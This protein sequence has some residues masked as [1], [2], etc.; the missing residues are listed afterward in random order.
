[1]LHAGD[2]QHRSELDQVWSWWHKGGRGVCSL[3]GIGG[4]GKTAIAEKFLD[5][6]LD[7]PD[8]TRDH[9]NPP[10]ALV[11]SFYDDDKPKNFF[12][13]LQF[14]LEG[15]STP[16]KEKSASQLMFDVQQQQGLIILDGL[17]RVQESGAR[18]G[19]GSLTSPS[20]RDL[21]NHVASG[22]AR[23][24]G[25]LVTSRFP[26]TDLR[27]SRPRFFYTISVAEI[28]VAT[29]VALLR[30]RGVTGSDL[31]LGEIVEH[32]GRHALTVDLAGGYIGEFGDGDPTTPLNLGSAKELQAKA[33]QEPDD[34]KRS[35]LKQEIRFTRIAQRYR[36]A[37]R[38]TDEA[39]LALL[40]R[41]CLFRMGVDSSTLTAIFTGTAAEESSSTD[42]ASL[43]A[44]QVQKKL[45]WLVRMHLIESSKTSP[46]HN[47]VHPAIRDGILSG[48]GA[49]LARQGHA[50]A[51]D[52]FLLSLGG[53]PG[54]FEVPADPETY[55]SIE[56]AIFH[57]LESGEP[58]VAHR[59]YGSVGEYRNLGWRL[60]QFERGERI[61]RMFAEAG[62]GERCAAN[63]AAY[64]RDLGRLEEAGAVYEKHVAEDY[65]SAYPNLLLKRGRL[66][67]A[68][69]LFNKA[70]HDEDVERSSAIV[71]LGCALFLRG[72]VEE[73]LEQLSTY[74]DFKLAMHPMDEVVYATLLEAI[75]RLDEAEQIAPAPLA[76]VE[77]GDYAIK[78]ACFSTILRAEILLERGEYSAA[79]DLNR[80]AWKWGRAHNA[81]EIVCAATITF[82]R[83][84]IEMLEADTSASDSEPKE[85]TDEES[86]R[87]IPLDLV[88]SLADSIENGLRIARG[89]GFGLLHIDMLLERAR[90][91]LLLG[92]PDATL[93]D[94]SI[95]LDTGIPAD[96]ATGQVDLLAANHKDCGYAWAV[97]VGLQLR[98]EALLLRVAQRRR[99]QSCDF[100]DDSSVEGA[101]IETRRSPADASQ[102]V[103]QAQRYLNEALEQ[104]HDLRDP[105]SGNTI[106]FVN[107]ETGTLYNYHAKAT[108]EA[109]N[110][111]NQGK[112]TRYPLCR[113]LAEA[114]STSDAAGDSTPHVETSPLV[115]ISYSHK[116]E[117][118]KDR[119]CSHLGVLAQQNLIET[120]DD[121]N[122]DAGDDWEPRIIDTIR[123][124]KAAVLLVSANFL[125]SDFILGKEVPALLKR[126]DEDGLRVIPVIIQPCAWQ[127]VDW[128][129]RLQCRPKDGRPLSL[130]EDNQI[131]QDLADFAIEINE[132]L[133]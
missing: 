130:G 84:Q 9:N 90:L 93:T 89:C 6:V 27:D 107:A 61:C 41:I 103:G 114:E 23:E 10:D 50:A 45:D 105:R 64:L 55:D 125:T 13:H 73:A 128:L 33:D 11:Y 111:L 42:L 48:F 34:S 112:L 76:L 16:E 131:E 47:I 78:D 121:R 99:N 66:R 118:W 75:G 120:W 22:A 20:L 101:S 85:S 68:Y 30:D 4:A 18:G 98:A 58:R 62:V 63:W 108:F 91:Q 97:P 15:T 53:I 82:A 71:G 119:L 88:N 132:L 46:G 115:F 39:A 5:E 14:W 54:D 74:Q 52:F 25:V 29:G 57:A 35:V 81:R 8:R 95:A 110:R 129:G 94:I 65:F 106:N 122:I 40:E 133:N 51:R 32:C 77:D 123:N 44:D 31:N 3:I 104:W 7:Q 79:R 37:L 60:G 24:L 28:D 80:A 21:L 38:N 1:M 69:D 117:T 72:H 116:D 2:W 43:D 113:I 67:N 109:L 102:E 126:R 59:L 87:V 36:E 124:A 17:E 12:R 70:I 83:V 127:A 92:D 100:C 19:F 56:E 86:A 96:A 49:S 26:L